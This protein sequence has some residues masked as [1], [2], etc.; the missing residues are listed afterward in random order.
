MQEYKVYATIIW[1]FDLDFVN[2]LRQALGN[3]PWPVEPTNQ[4]YRTYLLC[5]V[6][7]LLG[8][9]R[10]DQ[11]SLVEVARKKWPK[12]ENDPNDNKYELLILKYNAN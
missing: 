9:S 4:N 2:N 3:N 11:C 5:Q 12:N 8:T 7:Y 6:E 1:M 10:V